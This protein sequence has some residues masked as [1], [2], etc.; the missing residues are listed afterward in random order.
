MK[1]TDFYDAV[2][3]D[4]TMTA[5]YDEEREFVIAKGASGHPV[6]LPVSLILR[7][8]W[9][10]I[11]NTIDNGAPLSVIT[12]IVGYWSSTSSWNGGKI[13]ELA[14]RRAGSYRIDEQHAWLQP[15]APVAEVA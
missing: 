3:A 11:K 13:G 2:T 7:Y 5:T 6:G 12:R 8:Q 9:P 4:E 1:P 15:D 10:H 14:D